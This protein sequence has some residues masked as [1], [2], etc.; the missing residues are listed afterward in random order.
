MITWIVIGALL[1][2]GI[3][4]IRMNHLKHRLFI[5]LLVTIVLFLYVSTVLVKAKYDLDLTTPNGI[6]M[7]G[8]IYVG[9]LANG[10]NNM[11]AIT[12]HAVKLDWTNTNATFFN[13]ENK[14]LVE[15]AAEETKDL[16]KRF[17]G[18]IPKSES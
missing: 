17:P 6:V 8:K 10:F 16:A 5:L 1:V 2:L 12:G 4:A 15:T 13:K 18:Y 14:K 3:I 7:A 11:L 9:F